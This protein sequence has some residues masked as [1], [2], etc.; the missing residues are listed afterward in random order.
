LIFSHNQIHHELHLLYVHQSYTF[1]Q[2]GY[3]EG[4]KEEEK[5]TEF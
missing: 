2:E 1:E 5:I 4:T 3:K